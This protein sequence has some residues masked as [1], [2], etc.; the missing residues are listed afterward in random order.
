V[1]AS[2][3]HGAL[4]QHRAVDSNIDERLNAVQGGCAS[5]T[6]SLA[7]DVYSQSDLLGRQPAL[8]YE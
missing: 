8:T 4:S 6:D 3:A 5:H 2:T 1:A 7:A